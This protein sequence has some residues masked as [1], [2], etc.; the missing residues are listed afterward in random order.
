MHTDLQNAL[1]AIDAA[2][3]GLTP[4][5]IANPVPGKWSVA[6]VLEHLALACS[7]GAHAARKAVEA[8]RPTVTAPRLRQIAARTLVVDVGYFPRVRAPRGV[9]PSTDPN[10]QAALAAARASL[11]D[12]DVALDEAAARF[13]EHAPLF[14]HPYFGGMSAAQ[15]RRFHRRHTLH[16]V[17]QIR[18]RTATPPTR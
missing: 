5:Q 7:R 9:V 6:Q 10:P 1:D 3:R 2:T 8:G 17:A 14:D 13:G 16:H 18:E 12:I 15:W 11:A 4:E